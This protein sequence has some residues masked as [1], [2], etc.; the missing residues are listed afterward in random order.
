D[1]EGS[2]LQLQ[3]MDLGDGV[4]TCQYTPLMVGRHTVRCKF[5]GREI[6]ESPFLVPVRASGRPDLCRI[7]DGNEAKIPVGQ[8]CVITVNTSQA[9]VGQLT[10]RIVTPS[11]TNA[12]VA[13]QDNN[14]GTVS[15]YY[16]PQIRGDYTVEIRFGGEVIPGGRFNQKAVS[17][18]EFASRFVTKEHMTA[19][20][21]STITTGFHPVDFKL[22]VGPTFSHVEGVVKA[23]SGQL[24][25]PTL[26][27]N[28]D[29]TVTAQFQPTER[30]LHELEVTYNGNPV[31]GSPFRFY[32]ESVGSGS[33]T[34]YGPG[35]N[36]GRAGEPAEF[37]VVTRDAGAG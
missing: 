8:E 30:G 10:C 2:P 29:G 35:L 5:G 31:P 24:M 32:V 27:D 16:T 4:Y 13:I 33:V 1:P 12:D 7:E 14:N 6:P 23:P 18:D 22:P 17:P 19:L 37:T 20:H 9:G 36:Y 15:I 11:G 21:T 28:G 25:R 34:A 3:V 26:L